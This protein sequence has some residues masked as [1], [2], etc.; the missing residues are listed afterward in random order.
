[1]TFEAWYAAVDAKF[2]EVTGMDRDSFPD[3]CYYDMWEDEMEPVEAVAQS[4]EEGFG[5]TLVVTSYPELE[6]YL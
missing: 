2:V 5:L 3:A 1:M 6:Q 4:L